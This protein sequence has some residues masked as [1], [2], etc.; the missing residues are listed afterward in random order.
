M[1]NSTNNK[2]YIFSFI[3][4]GISS[5]F[6]LN[7]FLKNKDLS[8]KSLFHIFEK[9]IFPFGLVRNGFAPDNYKTKENLTKLFIKNLKQNN[10]VKYFGNV[11]MNNDNLKK[12]SPNYSLILSGDGLQQKRLLNIPNENLMLDAIDLAKW[13][14]GDIIEDRNLKY[15]IA[16]NKLNNLII[17][18]NG[19]VSLDIICI[20]FLI[21]YDLLYKYGVPEERIKY[22]KKLRNKINK[23]Y[24]IGRNSIDNPSFTKF[25]FKNFLR[26]C[27][28]LGN[29]NI[30]INDMKIVNKNNFYISKKI[31]FSHNSINIKNND[32]SNSYK[33][34]EIIFLFNNKPI[35]YDGKHLYLKNNFNKDKI[36]SNIVI[37]SIGRD[38]QDFI[39]INNLIRL[40]IYKN[41]SEGIVYSK[42]L[43]EQIMSQINNK[44][45][46]KHDI[47]KLNSCL[48]DIIRKNK[49]IYK[50]DLFKIDEY[51]KKEGIKK[52]KIRDKITEITNVFK[53][54]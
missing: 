31:N 18:G 2:K 32:G 47:Q 17:I 42:N 5:M 21:N 3:G 12:I 8:N 41:I 45:I 23:I 6:L 28:N 20:L 11:F 1:L 52:G 46:K 19:N 53:L 22:I 38:R 33:K 44:L 29:I 48:E 37:K 34:K 27:I 25:E 13:Y 35:R 4:S 7:E 43:Y 30:R 40:P 14:N 36:K 51:E 39:P 50:N 24:I 54:L 26:H 16:N 9:D 15:A 10:N 49:I